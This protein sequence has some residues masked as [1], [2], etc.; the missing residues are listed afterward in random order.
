MVLALKRTLMTFLALFFWTTIVGHCAEAWLVKTDNPDAIRSVTDKAGL[1][2]VY[3]YKHLPWA[4]YRS[5]ASSKAANADPQEGRKVMALAGIKMEADQAVSLATLPNVPN[6]PYFSSKQTQFSA[7]NVNNDVHMT[8]AWNVETDAS[9]VVVAVIDTGAQVTHPDLAANLWTNTD[10]THGR[11]FYSDDLANVYNDNDLTDTSDPDVP[12]WTSHGTGVAGIIGAC[13]NN[14]I[15]IAGVC[16]KAKLMIIR[17]TDGDGAITVASIVGGIDYALS[18]PAVRVVN[19][20][21]GLS[22]PSAA[23]SDAV[24]LL[25]ENNIVMVAAAGNDGLSL[26]TTTTTG[27]ETWYPASYATTCGNVISV[28]A[29]TTDGSLASF[30]NYGSSVTV[31]APGDGIYSIH[32]GGSYYSYQGTSFAAP[33]VSG[34]VALLLAENPN[35]TPLS[36]KQQVLWTSLKTPPLTANPLKPLQGGLLQIYELLRTQMAGLSPGAWLR[37]D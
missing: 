2:L 4:V 26:D 24:N 9:S 22:N 23:L 5:S 28:A 36:V 30:S 19:A 17:V 29:T 14:H 1:T 34:A 25:G 8:G 32:T 10:G 37:Y 27:S 7:P 18:F 16:W 33:I 31:A 35:L 3:Q 15:G 6:D 21:W 12:A 13:G 11:H 20:S